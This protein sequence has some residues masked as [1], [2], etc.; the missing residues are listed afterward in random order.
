MPTATAEQLGPYDVA[1]S[2]SSSLT[3][4]TNGMGSNDIGGNDIQGFYGF[5]FAD[6][7]GKDSAEQVR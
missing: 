5:S 6:L 2:P 7:E 3:L 1:S 4:V